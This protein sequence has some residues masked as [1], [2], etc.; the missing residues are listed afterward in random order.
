MGIDSNGERRHR[1][2]LIIPLSQPYA[3]CYFSLSPS[4]TVLLGI[5]VAPS[6]PWLLYL[7]QLPLLHSTVERRDDPPSLV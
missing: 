2:L 5:V 3:I 1:I 6:C 4:D 7:K